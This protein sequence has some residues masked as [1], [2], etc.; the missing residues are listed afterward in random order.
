[1]MNINHDRAQ[2]QNLWKRKKGILKVVSM[3]AKHGVSPVDNA[4]N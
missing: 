1:M 4:S 3:E 2:L